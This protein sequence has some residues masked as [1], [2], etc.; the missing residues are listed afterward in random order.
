M[1]SGTWGAWSA[2]VAGAGKL[3][4]GS[5]PGPRGPVPNGAAPAR[6]CDSGPLPPAL[7]APAR[8]EQP[9]RGSRARPAGR[10]I[11]GPPGGGPRGGRTEDTA[12]RLHCGPR[13]V[14]SDHGEVPKVKADED[15]TQGQAL[16][17]G[18]GDAAATALELEECRREKHCLYACGPGDEHTTQ[19][20]ARTRNRTCNTSVYGMTPEARSHRCQRCFCLPNSL[21]YA[22]ALLES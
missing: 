5:R 16:A 9:K 7:R 11:R 17:P 4:G 8:A 12:R 1:S 20:R 19:V 6:C 10:T 15:T 18:S 13:T 2:I 22:A 14:C 3:G 21:E